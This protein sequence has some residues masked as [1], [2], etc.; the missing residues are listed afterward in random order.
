MFVDDAPEEGQPSK[1]EY[2]EFLKC[3]KSYHNFL[4]LWWRIRVDILN[5]LIKS[6]P[7]Y[8]AKINRY[9]ELGTISK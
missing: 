4:E 5:E 1:L 7:E 3:L 6:E 2:E 9:S 8:E